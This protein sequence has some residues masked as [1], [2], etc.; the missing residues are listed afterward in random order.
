[1][2]FIKDIISVIVQADKKR[3]KKGKKLFFY[4]PYWL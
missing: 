4:M 1:M 2:E 3:K